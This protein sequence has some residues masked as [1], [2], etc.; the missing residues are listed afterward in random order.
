MTLDPSSLVG[1]DGW[2]TWE[3]LT[4]R[5]DRGTVARWVA[6]GRLAR[7]QPGVYALP[8]VAGDWRLRVEAA[9]R[10]SVGVVSHRSALALWEL[11]PPGGPVH[12]TVGHTRS[13]RGTAGVVLHR[14]RALEDGIRRVEGLPVSCPERAV[15]DTWGTPAGLTR[16]EVRAAAIDAVRRRLCRPRE[17]YAELDRRPC[18]PGRAALVDLVRLL[19][20]G[21]RSELEIWG[22]LTVLRRPGM[23]VFTQQRRLEVAGEVFV[24]DAAYDEVQLAVEMDGAAWHGSRAQRERDIRRDA[25]VATAG[26]QTLRFGYRRLTAEPE[27]CRAEI[28]AVHRVRR[29]LHREGVR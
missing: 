21:C 17:L 20:E 29:R 25:L 28:L 27:A 14:T 22:C 7:L 24:L 3:A 10:A 1:P 19:A 11:A 16:A 9:V 15:V 18:L 2:T 8:A 12:L 23:P 5:V 13:A 4:A 26:W 6:T